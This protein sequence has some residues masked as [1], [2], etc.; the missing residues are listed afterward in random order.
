MGLSILISGR[1]TLFE[2]LGLVLRMLDY[3]FQE[4]KNQSSVTTEEL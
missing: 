2:P 4:K 1:V 3:E